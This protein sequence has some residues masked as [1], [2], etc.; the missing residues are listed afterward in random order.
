[1][2]KATHRLSGLPTQGTRGQDL[3]LGT[4]W[5]R[6]KNRNLNV[7]RNQRSKS[8]VENDDEGRG[9]LGKEEGVQ[10]RSKKNPIVPEIFLFPYSD[11]QTIR[12]FEASG[13]D[14]YS[15]YFCKEPLVPEIF[16]VELHFVRF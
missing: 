12:I 8:E 11:R 15:A 3:V 5:G 9:R 6:A 4:G 10:F 1:L 2:T 7:N 13:E 16:F 14:N